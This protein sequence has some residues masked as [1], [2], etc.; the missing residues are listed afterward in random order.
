MKKQLEVIML[1]SDKKTNMFIDKTLV[2]TYHSEHANSDITWKDVEY[3]DLYFLSDEEIKEGDWCYSKYTNKIC[4]TEKGLVRAT[5]EIPL[6]KIVAT[7]NTSLKIADFPEL[8]NTAY[9]SLPQPHIEFIKEYV[10]EYNK[11][12]QIKF[13]D[14]EYTNCKNCIN[15]EGQ[16][17][18][19]DCCTEFIIKINSKNEIEITI[20]KD[21]VNVEELA[22]EYSLT[23]YPKEADEDTTTRKHK[24]FSLIQIERSICQDDFKAGYK[25]AKQEKQS[26]KQLCSQDA[27]LRNEVAGLFRD[28]RNGLTHLTEKDIDYTYTW[29][30]QNI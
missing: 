4:K 11:G 18:S 28:F 29:L 1:A 19:P 24:G 12:N 3:Q 23:Q 8:S 17:N 25:A 14:V 20:S 7:T 30:S 27:D 13:V 6:Q 10:D 9:R 15:I 26:L 22:K 16:Q 2:L 21:E 5:K